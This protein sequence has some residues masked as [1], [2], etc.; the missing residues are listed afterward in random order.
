MFFEV[1]RLDLAADAVVDDTSDRFHVLNVVAGDAV[2][3]ETSGGHRYELAYAE[4]LTLPAS[5]GAYRVHG[6]GTVRY[7]KALV[8]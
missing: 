6:V 5:V 1:R 8:R 7:V 2:L 3:V 4:T